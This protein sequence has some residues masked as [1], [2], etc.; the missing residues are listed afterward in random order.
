MPLSVILES[1]VRFSLKYRIYYMKGLVRCRMDATKWVWHSVHMLFFA[2][3]IEG[4]QGCILLVLNVV[5]AQ[6][7]P[8]NRTACF[9]SWSNHK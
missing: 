4:V 1:D 7:G 3:D 5:M 2:D 9:E 8:A 6:T